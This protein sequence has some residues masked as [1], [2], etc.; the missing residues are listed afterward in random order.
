M[1]ASHGIARRIEAGTA[2]PPAPMLDARCWIP[3][4]AIRSRCHPERA[5]ARRA[6]ASRRIWAGAMSI[7]FCSPAQTCPEERKRRRISAIMRSPPL[8]SPS[9]FLRPR[10]LRTALRAA[11]TRSLRSLAQDDRQRGAGILHTQVLETCG[12]EGL[13]ARSVPF[14]NVLFTSTRPLPEV[15]PAGARS[16]LTRS[17]RLPDT[18]GGLLPSRSPR[19]PPSTILG[20]NGVGDVRREGPKIVEDGTPARGAVVG[21]PLTSTI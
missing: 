13:W 20:M 14:R 8:C 6:G 11:S 9:Q 2:H 12:G 15:L 3:R 7:R 4:P 5:E 17:R 10:G 1:S 19:L 18:R 16:T 21:L